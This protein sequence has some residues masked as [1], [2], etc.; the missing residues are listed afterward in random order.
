[1]R[2]SETHLIRRHFA[3]DPPDYVPRERRLLRRGGPLHM[4]QVA[5]AKF[6]GSGEVLNASPS[7]AG[8]VLVP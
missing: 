6:A 7:L 5:F 3:F 8:D 1:M 4:R 2:W